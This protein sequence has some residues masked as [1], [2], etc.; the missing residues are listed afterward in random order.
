MSQATFF[1]SVY[2]KI[3]FKPIGFVAPLA[4]ALFLHIV[5]KIVLFYLRFCYAPFKPAPY[6]NHRKVTEAV[7]RLLSM[8]AL[9][10]SARDDAER[11]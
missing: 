10:K 11:F 3:R 5:H 8:E 1:V 7:S 9:I 6:Y 2:P 4:T